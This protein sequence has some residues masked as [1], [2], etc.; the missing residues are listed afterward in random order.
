MSLQEVAKHAGVS[1]ATVSRALNNN[2]AV[3][4]STRARILRA[5]A[6][7]NYYPNLNARSLAGGKN[8][9]L[10]MIASSLENPFFFDIFHALETRA[11]AH[12]FELLAANTD[13]QPERLVRSVRLMIGR[14][15]AGLA[16]IVSEMDPDLIREL[17]ERKIPTVFYDV[18]SAKHRMWNIRVNYRNGIER[19]VNYLRSLGH[20]QFAFIGHHSALSPTSERQQAFVEAVSRYPDTAWRILTNMDGPDGGKNATRELLATGFRPTAVIC[21]NDFMALGVLHELR[22][23]GLRVPQEVSVAGFD[24]IQLS[25][26]CY[27]PLTT[28]D[29]P[30]SRI[31]QLAFEALVPESCKGRPLGREIVVDPELILRESTGAVETEI[32]KLIERA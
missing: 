24:N 14:R 21:V 7:L 17:D 9:T 27:P 32:E 30:R 8:R 22:V 13:Y 12:G 25:Q 19:I 1:V 6:K 15:V 28:V 26:Y 11:R 3:K 31:G 18:G 4:A 23:Q 29:I 16:V 10:G 2:S 5:A 20:S